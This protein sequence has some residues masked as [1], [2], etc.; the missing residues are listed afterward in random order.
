M[1]SSGRNCEA[2][3]GRDRRLIERFLEMLAAER[4]AAANTIAAYGRD[5]DDY[6][7]FLRQRECGLAEAGAGEVRAYLE[8]LAA[9]GLARTTA[10][11]RL[12]AVRQLHRFLHGEGHARNDPTDTVEGPRAARPLPR[13]IAQSE[14]E[15]LLAAAHARLRRARGAALLKARRLVCLLELLY[16]T[17]LRVSELVTLTLA[18]ATAAREFIS[19]TGKGGRERI[20]PLTGR[21]RAAIADYAALLKCGGRGETKWL[22]PSFGAGGHLTRQHFGREL[23]RLAAEAGLDRRAVSPHVLRHGFASH[24]LAGGADLRA[25][26]QMLGHADIATTQ[27]YTHVEIARLREA[28]TRH[29]P[30]AKRS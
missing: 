7:G 21:A 17:G 10:A 27:I 9:V 13:L 11:R 16:A 4:G 19:V 24:L 22:F 29:H 1:T 18:A 5:L 8:A 2:E 26:Q 28:V 12:S 25:V 3:A 6:G 30:L 14:V 15:A 23:K 20:V